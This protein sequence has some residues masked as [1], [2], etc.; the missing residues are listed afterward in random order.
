MNGSAPNE[1]C[2]GSQSLPPRNE[3][4]PSLANAGRASFAHTNTTSPRTTSTLPPSA[5]SVAAKPRSPAA[6]L[7]S[8][9]GN[10]LFP[11]HGQIA[12]GRFDLGDD[13]LRERS[14]VERTGQRLAVMN[15]PPQ[16]PHQRLAL[17]RI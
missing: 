11:L 3:N 16:E 9:G 7:R 15:R 13:R 4:S 10:H 17:A 5:V 14:I 2:T 1:S 8:V 12:Q 6:A